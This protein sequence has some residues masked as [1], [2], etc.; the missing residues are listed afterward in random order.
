MHPIKI[1]YKYGKKIINVYGAEN[2]EI[3]VRNS[4]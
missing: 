4:T 3:Y 2:R 1:K